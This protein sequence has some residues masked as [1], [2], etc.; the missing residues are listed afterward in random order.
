MQVHEEVM[1]NAARLLA[2]LAVCAACQRALQENQ[3]VAKVLV[4]SRCFHG[5]SRCSRVGEGPHTRAALILAWMSKV[6]LCNPAL[7]LWAGC[8]VLPLI[9][10]VV[11]C[12]PALQL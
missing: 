12:N 10:K 6:V 9:C 4:S 11:L 8:S 5:P 1:L 3:E 2:K 7:Q